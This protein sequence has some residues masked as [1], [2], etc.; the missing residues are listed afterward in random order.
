MKIT[1][2]SVIALCLIG[3]A[4]S[5]AYSSSCHEFYQI[6][7]DRKIDHY[8]GH[9][10]RLADSQGKNLQQY[11]VL[12]RQKASYFAS[13]KNKILKDLKTRQD[14]LKPHQIDAYLNERFSCLAKANKVAGK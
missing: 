14:C 13:E 4:V 10:S 11:A 6:Y 2:I 7:L 8:I 9:A 1:F 12:C 5:S 3:P